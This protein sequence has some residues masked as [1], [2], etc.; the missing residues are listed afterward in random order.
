MSAVLDSPTEV[1]SSHDRVARA[2]RDGGRARVTVTSRATGRHLTVKLA[3]KVRGDDGRFVSRARRD[4][5]VGFDE[6]DAVFADSSDTALQ[7]EWLGTFWTDTASWAAPHNP[8]SDE[9]VPAY[10]WAARAVLR[11]A[12]ADADSEV[13]AKFDADAEA[14][15]AEECARCGKSLVDPESVAR[16]LGPEC[17]GHATESVHA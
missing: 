7:D 11:W 1:L 5:R 17:A 10:Q 8:G 4:G 13:A 3:C 2:L 9:R 6:A 14:V 16:G 12:M 15:L